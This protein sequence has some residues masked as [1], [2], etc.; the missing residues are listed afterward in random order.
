VRDYNYSVHRLHLRGFSGRVLDVGCGTSP[1]AGYLPAGV[2]YVAVDRAPQRHACARAAVERLPFADECFD[3]VI[4]TEVMEYT[5]RPWQAA[6]ELARVLRRGGRLYMTVPF[7]WHFIDQ[8]RDYYR[9]TPAG[10][11]AL[12]EDAG[13]VVETVEEVGGLFTAVSA[14]LLEQVVEGGLLRPS[15]ALG[16]K[17]GAYLVSALAALP[18]NGVT[19]ALGGALDRLSARSP[20]AVAAVAIRR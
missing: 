13:F 14:Q 19:V 1:Y 4:C 12:I 8:P 18:W 7:D 6:A 11:T 2:D 3:G 20:F 15:R 5:R 17:R 16:L 9:F 10:V